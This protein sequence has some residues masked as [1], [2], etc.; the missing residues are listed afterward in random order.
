MST[1]K[2]YMITSAL[3]YTNGPVHIGQLAGAYVPADIYV[4]Y[5]RLKYGAENV[6]FICGSDEHGAAIT[7][8]AIKEGN[9]PREIVDKYNAI[10]K[11][12]FTDFGIDF[13][14]YHRTS[15]ELHHETASQFFK[16]LYDKGVFIEK[17]SEQYYDEKHQQFLADRY[18][19]GTCPVCENDSAYGD[20][21]EKCGSTLDPTELKNP[22]ST[23][24]N[25]TPI[26]K[27]TKHL[28]LS[29]D[30]MQAW[31]EE[32]IIEG[33]GREE[34]WKKNV[35]GACKSWLTE[36]LRPRSMTRDLDWGVKVPVEGYE[37]K[38]L[39]VWFDAPL[40]YISATKEWAA[41]NGRDW[42]P[43]WKDEETKLVHFIGKDNIVFHCITFPA[44]LKMH[45]DYIVPTN[46]PAN[47]FMNMEGDKMSTSR[48]WTV[49]L[50]EYL[51]EFPGKQ[52]VLRYALTANMPETKDSEFT[53]KD[54]QTRNNSELAGGLGNFV[55]RVNVLTHKYFD[56]VVPEADL[57][58]IDLDLLANLK[59]HILK[60]EDHLEQYE[61]RSGLNTLM[62][63]VDAGDKYLT[64]TEPWKL[65]KTDEARTKTVLYTALQLVASL[66]VLMKPYLPFS[67]AKLE[68][69]LNT[70][71]N[72]WLD[73]ENLHLLPSGHQ[74]NKPELLFTK[75]EDTDIAPQLAKLDAI[76]K[77]KEANALAA[78]AGPESASGERTYVPSKDTIEYDDFAKLDLRV[79]TV[80]EA[81]KVKKADRL[82]KFTIDLGYEQRTIVSGIAEH[83][84]PADLIGKQVCVV[85]NLAPRKL[86]G[87]ESQGMILTADN[88][89]GLSLIRPSDVV[90][91]GEIIS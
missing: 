14:M 84:D 37:G 91:N 89:D 75:I 74:I 49:W 5:L 6:A 77:E 62:K 25:T 58:Q 60:I 42:E 57:Q 16:D 56:G 38:V 10:I 51:Q 54:F 41:E 21:C 8:K 39:Y 3:P 47:E 34:K 18:I 22:I 53:W 35:M 70:S 4:R 43:F 40:G 88:R 71:S 20:Q 17:E 65:I 61:F 68:G 63:L 13:D 76:R 23:L 78:A 45:G 48:N 12:S 79:G 28:F 59:E 44:I 19:K 85:A 36:G 83:Y 72:T 80:L 32:W 33:K 9:T 82:L 52:D 66:A 29:L 11:Q 86:R 67:A 55:N 69:I 90:D 15:A 24:S 46:V 26:R 30:M 31:L 64:V 87:I 27:K 81:E 73:V 7:L 2:R 1:P 50:H